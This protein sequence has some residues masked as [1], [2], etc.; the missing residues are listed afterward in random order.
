MRYVEL[1]LDEPRAGLAKLHLGSYEQA[2]GWC[3]RAIEAN[4]NYPHPHFVMG[5]ALALLG[6]LDEA[7]SSV[8]A[9]LA[10]NPS[11]TISS[12]RTTWTTMSDDPT[13]LA[14]LG[15]LL[16]GMRKAGVP[17]Q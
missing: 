10:L 16:D 17:E 8:R 13:H 7:R 12:A 14:Q 9:G 2:A 4:R 6:R 3:R 11:F 1:C 5:V 15:R